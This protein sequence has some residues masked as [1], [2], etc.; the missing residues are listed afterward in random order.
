[1]KV[2]PSPLRGCALVLVTLFS[3]HPSALAQFA[4][5]GSKLVGMGAVGNAAQG[6]SVALSADGTTAV[7]GGYGDNSN[8]GAAWIYTRSGNAWTQQGNK[9]AP[10]PCPRRPVG[11]HVAELHL[12]HAEQ[13]GHFGGRFPEE[14][15]RCTVGATSLSEWAAHDVVRPSAKFSGFTIFYSLSAARQTGGRGQIS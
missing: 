14:L 3:S 8:A 5:Q 15:G 4:Q 10:W 2:G 11:E 6:A 9:A 1:M 7:V 12:H 13:S